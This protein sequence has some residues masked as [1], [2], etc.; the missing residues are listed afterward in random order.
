M[1]LHT[2]IHAGRYGTIQAGKQTYMQVGK[3]ASR[4]TGKTSYWQAEIQEFHIFRQA[5]LQESKHSYRKADRLTNKVAGRKSY[6]QAGSHAEIHEDWHA[7]RQTGEKTPRWA[8]K[9][10]CK[11]SYRQIVVI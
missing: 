4:Y 8:D 1:C 7:S 3:Q 6:M 10:A 5:A 9:E 2:I 11:Q